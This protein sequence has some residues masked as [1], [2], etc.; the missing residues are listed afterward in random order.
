MWIQILLAKWIYFSFNGNQFR[1]ECEAWCEICF[2]FS[3][4]LISLSM[5]NLL[6]LQR[7]IDF[8]LNVKSTSPSAWNR[9]PT[10]CEIWFSFS[11]KSISYSMW[12]LLLLQR[13]TDF[14]LI[15]KSDSP[16]AWNWVPLNVKSTSPSTWNLFLTQC[17]ALLEIN[18]STTW[19]GFLTQ[20]E[21]HVKL[22]SQSI[23]PYEASRVAESRF[24]LIKQ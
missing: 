2:S 5:W 3:V 24:L 15:V 23:N 1:T 10:Q 14:P 16:S 9:F 8:P 17:E 20:C 21:A 4:K 11:V 12:N 7:E 19:S 18:F 6:L 13:E 22:V